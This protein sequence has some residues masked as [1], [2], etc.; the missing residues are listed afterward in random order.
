MASFTDSNPLIGHAVILNRHYKYG[1][2][3][4]KLYSDLLLSKV[5]VQAVVPVA[6]D[7][8][9]LLS[10]RLQTQLDSQLRTCLS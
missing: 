4:N 7:K 5:R 6:L 9:A 3:H 8:Q 2:S 10:F 1:Q